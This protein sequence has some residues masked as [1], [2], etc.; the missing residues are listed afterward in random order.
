MRKSF[1]KIGIS[2]FGPH[3]GLVCSFKSLSVSFVLLMLRCLFVYSI[4]VDVNPMSVE[5][6]NTDKIIA[7]IN[8]GGQMSVKK[9]FASN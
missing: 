7:P 5:K 8:P 9:P 4:F 6:G 3:L 1:L 2:R